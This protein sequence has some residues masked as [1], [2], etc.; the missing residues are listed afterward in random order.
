VRECDVHCQHEIAKDNTKNVLVVAGENK[1]S[2]FALVLGK[3]MKMVT[4]ARK[5]S[6]LVMERERE[7]EREEEGPDATINYMVVAGAVGQNKSPLVVNGMESMVDKIR[8]ESMLRAKKGQVQEQKAREQEGPDVTINY[9]VAAGAVGQNKSPL[10]VNGR[11]NMVDEARND[12]R[13]GIEKERAQEQEQEQEQG[14]PDVT[15]I[16]MVA[17]GAVGQN[18]SPLVMNEMKNMDDEAREESSLAHCANP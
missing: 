3:M 14:K 8:E 6:R 17:A 15:N 18:L 11:E 2:M 16:Y 1:E 5:E 9:M 4:E 10:V 12:S 13:L 7:Q